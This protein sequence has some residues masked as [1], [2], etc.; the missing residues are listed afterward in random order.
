MTITTKF[1]SSIAFEHLWKKFEGVDDVAIACVYFNWQESRTTTDIVANLLKQLLERNPTL[2]EEIKDRYDQYQKRRETWLSAKDILQLLQLEASKIS[3]FFIF[4]DALDECTGGETSC[5][6]VLLELEKIPN[7]RLMITGRPGVEPVVLSKCKDMATL[8]IRASD[9][10]I[11]KA[12]DTQLNTTVNIVSEAMKDDSTLRSAILDAIVTHA[13]GMYCPSLDPSTDDIRFLLVSLYLKFLEQQ[14]NKNLIRPALVHLPAD[15]IKTYDAAIA[16]IHAEPDQR[17]VEIALK[18]LLWITFSREP[19]Q[20]EALLHALAVSED[21]MDSRPKESDFEDVQ[22]VVSLCVGLASV[23]QKGGEIRLIHETT[24][25]YLQSYFLD[26]RKE[27]GH[28]AIAKA[29]LRYFSFPAFSRAFENEQS[30]QEH[31]DKYK[32]SSYASR[33]WFVHIREGNLEEMFVASILK[34]FEKQD[35]RDSVFQIAEYLKGPGWFND[36]YPAAI[37]LLHLASM[38]GLAVLCREILRKTSKAQRL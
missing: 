26:K 17:D 35:I 34:S 32:L 28:W 11:R 15:L 14:R 13:R 12:I 6:K 21:E 8:E 25:Q 36:Y 16:R 24:R 4:L 5:A 22:K 29:C 2:P 20:T 31:L 10:D 30:L 7:V 38:H 1:S 27:D 18:A 9:E 3:S 19:L 23:D 37:Q 33:Y